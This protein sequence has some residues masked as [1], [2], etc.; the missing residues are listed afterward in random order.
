[1]ER[2]P[3]EGGENGADRRR[4]EPEDPR[5]AKER[6]PVEL[7]ADELVD[8]GVLDVARLVAAVLVETFAAFL[9]HRSSSSAVRWSRVPRR[10]KLLYPQPELR[11][12]F[13]VPR[14]ISTARQSLSA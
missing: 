7:A 12:S 13:H 9:P 14:P 3:A 6:A 11:G 2:S 4:R 1:A 10:P 5:A 8:Q